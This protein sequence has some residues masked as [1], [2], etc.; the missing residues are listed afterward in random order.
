MPLFRNKFNPKKGL[1]RKSMSLS[2][3]NMDKIDQQTDSAAD[4]GPVTIKLGGNEMKFDGGS[5]LSGKRCSF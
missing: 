4:Y 1:P 2:N 5:W 3:L